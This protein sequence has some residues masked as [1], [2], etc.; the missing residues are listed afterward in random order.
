MSFDEL[1]TK[2]PIFK[3]RNNLIDLERG[4]TDKFLGRVLTIIDA[5]IADK[6]QRKAIKDLIK[7]EYYRDGLDFNQVCKDTLYFFFEDYFPN[8]LPDNKDD[9]A[10]IR[11]MEGPQGSIN[12]N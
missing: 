5:T 7:N 3:L 12:N 11:G 8:A 6:E 4:I 1:S 2:Y 9:R 10:A